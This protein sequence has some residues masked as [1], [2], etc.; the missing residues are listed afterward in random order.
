MMGAFAVKAQAQ[1]ATK[2]HIVGPSNICLNSFASFNVGDSTNATQVKSHQWNF[3]SGVTFLYGNTTSPYVTVKFASQYTG[4]IFD[5]IKYT[6]NGKSGTTILSYSINV[7]ACPQTD[8]QGNKATQPFLLETFDS[9]TNNSARD[10]LH[11]PAITT[12][13]YLPS[14]SI[15]DGQYIVSSNPQNGRPE[16][17]N[18]SDHTGNPYGG[19]MI[20]NASYQP[21]T[22]YRRTINNLCAGMQYS[23]S[24][25]LLNADGAKVLDTICSGKNIFPNLS[26]VVLNAKND[27]LLGQAKTL[28]VSMNLSGPAWQRY[29]FGFKTP[30][31][32]DS[33]KL[34][35]YNIAPGGCGNDLAI[36]D[37]QF[38]YCGP[39]LLATTGSGSTTGDTICAGTPDTLRSSITANYFINPQYQ[40][41]TSTDSV[42]WTN[43][44]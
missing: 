26:F 33:V 15:N 36:D 42:N 19:M 6:V 37:I 24:A 28:D 39:T 4:N 27:S 3:P 32:V 13:Q 17:V 20:V 2:A 29:G 31:G 38:T 12:Y 8:C 7:T 44:T 5:T 21:D 18:T 40:W 41:Q 22:F 9:L 43:I 16:W 25:W 14:G 11:Y 23:F 10:S 30:V 35:M 34:I 1:P